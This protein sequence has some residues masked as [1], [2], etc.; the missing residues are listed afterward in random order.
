MLINSTTILI[1][2]IPVFHLNVITVEQALCRT[3]TDK[4]VYYGFDK[5][6]VGLNLVSVEFSNNSLIFYSNYIF[7]TNVLSVNRLDTDSVHH[8]NLYGN[9]V[10]DVTQ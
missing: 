10:N 6:S 1:H 9:S 2:H 7:Y 4:T 3:V 8:N 5:V